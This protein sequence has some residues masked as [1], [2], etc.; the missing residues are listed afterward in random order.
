MNFK[1][2]KIYLIGSGKT[3]SAF[4]YELL[5]KRY[6]LE[7]VTGRNLGKQKNLSETLLKNKV[8]VSRKIE[9]EFLNESDVIFLM[10]QDSLIDAAISEIKKP[11]LN[12]KNKIFI[13]ISGSLSSHVF[14]ML[15]VPAANCVSFHPIQTFG[16]IAAGGSDLENIFFGIEGGKT[17]SGYVKNIAKDFHSGIIKINAKDKFLYHTISVFASNYLVGLVY[18]ASKILKKIGADEKK[19]YEIYEPIIK[20]TLAN[21]KQKGVAKSLTGPID[22]NDIK[23][24]ER[25]AKELGMAD[26][27]LHDLYLNFGLLAAELAEAKR[28]INKKEKTKLD[29]LLKKY[30]RAN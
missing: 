14:K 19:V 1:K 10:V 26:K 30:L 11:G 13:Q 6:S 23:I 7:F 21:I 22:R 15:N 20:K 8:R 5:K 16:N 4:V 28:S 24:I 12:L 9:Y 25:H 29:S 3:G 2:K 27:R 18:A 17:A